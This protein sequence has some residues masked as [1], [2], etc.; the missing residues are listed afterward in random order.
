[1]KNFYFEVEG[2]NC[3]SCVGKIEKLKEESS[4]IEELTV[5]LKDKQIKLLG[6][7]DFSAMAFRKKLSE[8][9]FSVTKM[10]KRS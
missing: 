5:L 9:G 10:E 4:S 1:M 6:Q 8:L 3:Q 7:D 2:I